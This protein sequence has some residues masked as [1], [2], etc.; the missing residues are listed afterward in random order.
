MTARY[1]VLLRGIN[2][3][4]ARKVPMA[5]LREVLADLG[6]DDVVTY[7][8]SGNAVL[9]APTDA[10]GEEAVAARIEAG[11][12]KAFGFRVETLVRDGAHLRAVADAC[13]FP[14][15]EL[16][17]KQLHVTFLSGAP[18]AER[19]AA[20]DTAALLPE[21]FRTGD[22]VLYLYTPDGLGRSRLAQ[23]LARPSLFQGL[24]ATTRN[25]N[26]VAKLVEMTRER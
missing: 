23:V 22:R 11:I 3:G 1:A 12:E 14:A 2:V 15:A 20:V 19:L 6:Y 4:G 13:P 24:V 21:E 17:G 9:S 5:R 18:D 8:Q 26:T 16:Q 10:G 25:W 7:L